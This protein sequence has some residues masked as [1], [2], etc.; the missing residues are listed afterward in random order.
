MKMKFFWLDIYY[1]WDY[2]KFTERLNRPN[3]YLIYFITV[4]VKQIKCKIQINVYL[5]RDTNVLFD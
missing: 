5:L 3:V 2:F 1:L 4:T